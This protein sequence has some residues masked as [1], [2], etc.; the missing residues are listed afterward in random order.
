MKTQQ[1]AFM[2]GLRFTLPALLALAG[3]DNGTQGADTTAEQ[4]AADGDLAANSSVAP[5][6]RPPGATDTPAPT[7]IPAAI[8]GRWEL[9]S[10]G[11][12]SDSSDGLLT[13]SANKLEFYE[14]VGTLDTIMDA[15]PTR[16]RAEFDFEGE[17]M[18]W[19]REI[20]LEVQDGGA[21]L[22]RREYGDDAAPGPFRYARC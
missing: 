11:C 21:T 2:K 15:E 7:E 13:I 4:A 19:E 5:A 6:P 17:G 1:G 14:S 12:T 18:T 16:V 10:G 9:N 8:R 3:C 20:V 22:I